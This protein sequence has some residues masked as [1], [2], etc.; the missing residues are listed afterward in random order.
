MFTKKKQFVALILIVAG[1]CL[2]FMMTVVYQKYRGLQVNMVLKG[3]EPEPSLRLQLKKPQASSL[4]QQKEPI[5]LFSPLAKVPVAEVPTNIRKN[6]AESNFKIKDRKEI[7]EFIHKQ[8]KKYGKLTV[9]PGEA[10]WPRKMVIAK[11][12]K[13]H[14]LIYASNPKT[15]STSFKKWVSRMQGNNNTYD[16]I[17]HVHQMGR[18]GNVQELFDDATKRLGH[19]V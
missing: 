14:K 13:E 15:G 1:V 12:W 6:V 5:E 18:Y 19:Q 16:E 9:G 7:L 2:C 4:L 11:N 17:R 3:Q 8:C 10:K